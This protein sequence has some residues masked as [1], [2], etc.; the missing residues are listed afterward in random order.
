MIKVIEFR[1]LVLANSNIVNLTVP[2]FNGS[3]VIKVYLL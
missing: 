3:I 2:F 1:I